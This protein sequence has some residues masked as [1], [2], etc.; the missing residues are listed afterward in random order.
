MPQNLDYG[1]Q[2]PDLGNDFYQA[3]ANN[4]AVEHS[5]QRSLIRLPMGATMRRK[6]ERLDDRREK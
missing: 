2:S 5:P 4:A 1:S 6:L 3:A